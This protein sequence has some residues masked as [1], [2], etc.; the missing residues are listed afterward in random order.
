MECI[1]ASIGMVLPSAKDSDDEDDVSENEV[2]GKVTVHE[3]LDVNTSNAGIIQAGEM[4]VLSRNILSSKCR[5]S[6]YTLNHQNQNL[7]QFSFE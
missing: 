1:G 5:D 3:N 6:K 7:T 4:T 2:D